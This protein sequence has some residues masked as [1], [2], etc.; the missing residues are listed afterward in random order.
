ME[1]KTGEYSKPVVFYDNGCSL[2]SREIAHYRKLDQDQ[3]IEF[4]DI[5]SEQQRLESVGL[6]YDSA[7]RSL[8]AINKNG[9]LVNGVPAFAEIWNAIPRYRILSRLLKLPGVTPLLNY[10]YRHFAARRYRGRC[11]I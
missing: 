11:S 7:M 1:N 4:V 9:E 6:D 3:S 8:H 10:F 2:C 5:T